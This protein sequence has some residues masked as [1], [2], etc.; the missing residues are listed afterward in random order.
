M[1]DRGEVA[2]VVADDEDVDTDSEKE[3]TADGETES[4]AKT[5]SVWLVDA[6]RLSGDWAGQDV[7]DGRDSE[8]ESETD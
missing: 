6:V 7:A 3:D 1:G 8:M 2:A 5:D 4:V